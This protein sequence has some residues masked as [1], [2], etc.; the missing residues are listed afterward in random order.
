MP[1]LALDRARI[2]RFLHDVESHS[3]AQTQHLN[4]EP[5]TVCNALSSNEL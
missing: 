5:Q 2:P 4:H 3:M 1:Q